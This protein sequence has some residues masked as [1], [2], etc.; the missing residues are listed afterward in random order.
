MTLGSSE[1]DD[2]LP[3][4][5]CTLGTDASAACRG[6]GT[7]SDLMAASPSDF[8]KIVGAP[9]LSG[10][11]SPVARD[12]PDDG[13]KARRSSRLAPRF[14]GLTPASPDER[15]AASKTP[16]ANEAGTELRM[17]VASNKRRA[18]RLGHFEVERTGGT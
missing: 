1:I 3:S 9:F 12:P 8:E 17:P 10:D 15:A 18:V 5:D 13:E 2:A 14:R 11:P 16:P 4:Q 6:L 7:V